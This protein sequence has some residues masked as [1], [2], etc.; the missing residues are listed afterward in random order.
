MD[1]EAS[2]ATRQA[3]VGAA[4]TMIERTE[5]RFAIKPERLAGDTCPF[6]KS[7]PRVAMMQPR[8]DGRSGNVFVSLDRATQRQG[9]DL[10]PGARHDHFATVTGVK[11]K[12][13]T[14]RPAEARSADPAAGTETRTGR[15]TRR[16]A[17]VMLLRRKEPPVSGRGFLFVG[18]FA[19][20]ARCVLSFQNP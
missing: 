18:S 2:R 20:R 9:Q 1:V 14:R 12:A 5:Q 17:E 10:P 16:P 11:P 4:K 6:R 15:P 7:Y 8:Q 3:E 19:Y 13:R